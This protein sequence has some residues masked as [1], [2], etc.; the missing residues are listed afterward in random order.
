MR[1]RLGRGLGLVEPRGEVGDVLSERA[2][3]LAHRRLADEVGHE[4]ARERLVLHPRVAHRRARPLPQRLQ[5][6]VG[7]RVDG[8]L[9]RLARLLARV[10]VAEARQA[11]GLDVVLA[12]PRPVVDPARRTIWRRS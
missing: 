12:L 3:A 8:A 7:E 1:Q 9:A 11:L 5:A 4:Q 10:E 2:E 6:L